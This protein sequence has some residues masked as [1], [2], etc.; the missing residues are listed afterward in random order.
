MGQSI[1]DSWPPDGVS[2]PTLEAPLFPLPGVFLFPHQLM[3]LRVFE[4]PYRQMIEDCLDGPGRL[5]L[6]TVTEEQPEEVE[7]PAVLP[8]GGIGEIARHEKTGDGRF[9][10]WLY[11]LARVYIKELPSDRLYR[12]VECRPVHEVSASAQEAH[13]LREPLEQAIIARSPDILNLPD[14][15]PTGFLTDLLSQRLQLPQPEMERLYVEYHVA[16]RARMALAAHDRFPPTKE[17]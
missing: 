16:R 13:D 17:E 6:A 11:G 5:V 3:P 15:V 14:D 1:P 2:D 7:V 10:V 8:M 12:R 9:Y 4:D